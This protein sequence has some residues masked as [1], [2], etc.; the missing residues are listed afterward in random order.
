MRWI[1]GAVSAGSMRAQG[2][3]QDILLYSRLPF[4]EAVPCAAC[5]LPLKIQNVGCVE[6]A[7]LRDPRHRKEILMEA[8]S[9]VLRNTITGSR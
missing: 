9:L 7:K 1:T 8:D 4:T 3:L 2:A 6:L 5:G